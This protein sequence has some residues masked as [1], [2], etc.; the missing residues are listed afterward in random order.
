[1]AASWVLMLVDSFSA[2]LLS[3]FRNLVKLFFWGGSSFRKEIKAALL[4]EHLQPNPPVNTVHGLGCSQ[5][6]GHSLA[7][8][9]RLVG[10]RSLFEIQRNHGA[11]KQEFGSTDPDSLCE[12]GGW[13]LTSIWQKGVCGICPS[14]SSL[15]V[16]RTAKQMLL[17]QVAGLCSQECKKNNV[18]NENIGLEKMTQSAWWMY[19]A[20]WSWPTDHVFGMPALRWIM[21]LSDILIGD[22]FLSLGHKVQL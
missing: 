14:A 1:M 15:L 13:L 17:Q 12:M 16:P 10:V 11:T 18:R 2:F 8:P 22:A 6:T 19:C 9:E 7:S 3:F 4:M 20:G 5:W 21:C